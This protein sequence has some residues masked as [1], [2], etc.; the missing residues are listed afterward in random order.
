MI[1]ITLRFENVIAD[2][3]RA[4]QCAQN[5]VKF[6]IIHKSVDEFD[7]FGLVFLTITLRSKVLQHSF[8]VMDLPMSDY[9]GISWL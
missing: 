5:E 1:A 3:I 7:D 9:T 8:S 6:L 2:L 4:F